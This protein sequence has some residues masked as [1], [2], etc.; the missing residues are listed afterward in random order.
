MAD[1]AELQRL[2]D[3]LG[4][5]D[6][7]RQI[8]DLESVIIEGRKRVMEIDGN[9]ASSMEPAEDLKAKLAAADDDL[10]YLKTQISI[11]E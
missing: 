3:G 4:T 10:A 5:D 2:I 9:I 11:A 1:V 8:S 6:L 7:I